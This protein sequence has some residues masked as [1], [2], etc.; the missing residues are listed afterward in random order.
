M[1]AARAALA[2]R[3][4]DT[5]PFLL[6]GIPEDLDLDWGLS[7][8][9]RSLAARAT[10]G[11]FRPRMEEVKKRAGLTKKDP[12]WGAL[13]DA[14]EEVLMEGAAALVNSP[15]F[16][17]FDLDTLGLIGPATLSWTSATPSRTLSTWSPS[18]RPVG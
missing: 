1:A 14:A 9:E 5:V 3:V 15:A 4:A 16:A 10:M 18:A 13:D 6:M 2:D 11:D 8:H 12:V 17:G 7:R